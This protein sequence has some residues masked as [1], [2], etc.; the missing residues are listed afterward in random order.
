MNRLE[1]K[2][3]PE[4]PN[5]PS[6]QQRAEQVYDALATKLGKGHLGQ[7]NFYF[8]KVEIEGLMGLLSHR[9]EGVW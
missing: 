5:T 2:L 4:G 7:Q 6:Y 3:E 8:D 1:P 9:F